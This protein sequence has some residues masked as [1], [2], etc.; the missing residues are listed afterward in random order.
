MKGLSREQFKY[1]C[2]QLEARLM[3]EILLTL[4][5]TRKRKVLKQS[6]TKTT[7]ADLKK[8]YYSYYHTS[9][10]FIVIIGNFLLSLFSIFFYPEPTSLHLSPFFFT[11]HLL[12]YSFSFLS[13]E[14]RFWAV[15]SLNTKFLTYCE[16]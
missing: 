13:S 1:R 8:K 2:L 16:N 10:Y 3:R 11:L 6:R 4:A 7:I 9:Q 15:M 12:I 5:C 14:C